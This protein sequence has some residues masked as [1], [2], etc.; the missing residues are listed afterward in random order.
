MSRCF[1]I[2]IAAVV[3]IQVAAVAS[4]QA[5]SA[6][7]KKLQQS[8]LPEAVQTTAARESAQGKVT[9]YW[10]HDQNGAVTYEMDLVV[11]GKARGVLINPEGVVVAVQD[12]VSWELLDPGVQAGLK[13]QAGDGKVS[14]VYSVSKDGQVT[15]YIAIVEKGGQKT[16]VQVGP[17][18]APPAPPAGSPAPPAPPAERPGDR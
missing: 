1:R 9:A 7:A 8:E 14:T 3:A 12:E 13:S 2:V 10:Q 17:D 4:A 15:R 6:Q 16:K 18:G 5:A 11:D